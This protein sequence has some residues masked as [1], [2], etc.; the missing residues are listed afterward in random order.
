MPCVCWATPPLTLGGAQ[1]ALAHYADAL[2]LDKELGFSRK[3]A[4]DL[5][6]LAAAS[7]RLSQTAE[8]RA[9]AERAL[10][11]S[12]AAGDERLATQAREQI[13]AGGAEAKDTPAVPGGAPIR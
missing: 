9:F 4:V 13:A 5:L 3:V 6:G 10:A 12:T 8:A 1:E 2:A 11:V 7:R